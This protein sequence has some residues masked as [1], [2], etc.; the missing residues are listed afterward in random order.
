VRRRSSPTLARVLLGGLAAAVA[1]DGRASSPGAQTES[2]T[3]ATLA[4]AMPSTG[5]AAAVVAAALR[6]AGGTF[7][8]PTCFT[9]TVEGNAVVDV[10]DDCTGPRGLVHVTGTLTTV[11]TT[12]AA[13]L[14]TNTT[15]T[16]LQIGKQ[17]LD[18]DETTT[19]SVADGTRTVTVASTSSGTTALG[20]A[21]F[22]EAEYTVARG[23]GTGCSSLDGSWTTTRG[24]RAWATT[25]AS[26]LR[27]SHHCPTGTFTHTRPS[28][29]TTTITFDGTDVASYTRSSG[30]SGSINLPCVPE[31]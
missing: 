14:H 19:T 16:A 8:P 28:G 20:H 15:A 18:L 27:C 21:T 11:H 24:A 6:P 12:D 31:P 3:L 26:Y 23:I 29:V 22:H 7:Q 10:L 13:G 9:E 25:A 2:V 4:R 1:T 5:S 30:R 17:T